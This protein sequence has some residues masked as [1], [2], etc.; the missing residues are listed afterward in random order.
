M[1]RFHYAHFARQLPTSYLRDSFARIAK[2]EVTADAE[3]LFNR[4]VRRTAPC[5][6]RR[7]REPESPHRSQVGVGNAH[8]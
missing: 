3:A 1:S 7:I 2:R 5:L 8:D 4:I 6:L